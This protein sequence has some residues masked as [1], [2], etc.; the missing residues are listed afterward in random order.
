[1]ILNWFPTQDA[2]KCSLIVAMSVLNLGYVHHILDKF[3][4]PIDYLAIAVKTMNQVRCI[5]LIKLV[6][7]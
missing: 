3:P 7:N 2:D 4:V 5:Y 6:S 1:M